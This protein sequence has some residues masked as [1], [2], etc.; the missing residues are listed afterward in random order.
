[1]AKRKRMKL[2]FIIAAVVV[3]ATG[4]IAYFTAFAKS[5]SSDSI[6]TFRFANAKTGNIEIT[7]TGSGTVSASTEYSLTAENAGTIDNLPV[8]QGDR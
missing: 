8:K 7:V 4:G 3:V 5:G 2:V 6:T 1:M